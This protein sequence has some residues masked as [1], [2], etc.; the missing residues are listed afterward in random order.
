MNSNFEYIALIEANKNLKATTKSLFEEVYKYYQMIENYELYYEYIHKRKKERVDISEEV[1]YLKYK[2]AYKT[3]IVAIDFKKENQELKDMIY[4]LTETIKYFKEMIEQY[5]IIY[6]IFIYEEK[7]KLNEN[8][9]S[10]EYQ[11]N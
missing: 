2:V 7:Y 8:N 10:F 3:T 4:K 6:D 5:K 9:L 11:K 1:N